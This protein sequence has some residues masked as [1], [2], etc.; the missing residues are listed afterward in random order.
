MTIT[1]V[2]RSTGTGYSIEE[3]FSAVRRVVEQ[4][5]Y[6]TK[7]VQ[8]PHIG[9]SWQT[10]W[11]NMQVARKA[12]AGAGL[13]HITGD[14]HYV[15]LALPRRQT[16][17][18]VHDCVTL[19]KNRR[20][21]LRFAFFWLFWYYLPV[22]W[23]T[24]VTVV[25]DKTR[26]ELIR[27]VG[28]IAQKAVVISNGYHPLFTRQPVSFRSECPVLLQVG[29]A[30]HKNL[31]RLITA[32]EGICCELLIVG[33]LTEEQL[34]NLNQK[35]IHYEHYVDLDLQTLVTLYKR[36]DLITFVS[37]YEGFGL[38]I[39]EANAVGRV[40]VTSDLSP[41]C[42]IAGSASHLVDPFDVASIRAG[43]LRIMQDEGYRNE[44]I[45][46]GYA[47]ARR[48]SLETAAGAYS[49][50]YQQVLREKILTS[51]AV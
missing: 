30:P 1:Y 10:L 20:R 33:P 12:A 14:V 13:V 16:V 32:L 34:T 47:N 9:R 6:T 41:M 49:T 51:V 22:R 19:E 25:S 7:R 44:L 31:D 40:V 48:Y 5:G 17:L 45:Q 15:A 43:I 42:E 29:T 39:L 8:L 38:P 37:T 23:A 4:L 46:A 26:Q 35:Q 11:R 24:V 36:C 21:P 2:F 28:P 3:Q 18:T 27:Y 50:V